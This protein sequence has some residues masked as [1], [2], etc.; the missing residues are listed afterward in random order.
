M[1]ERL[2]SDAGVV[3]EIAFRAR[4]GKA[5][6]AWVVWSGE[7]RREGMPGS[8]HHCTIHRAAISVN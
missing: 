1:S 6:W 4:P 2:F 8:G 7:L 5:G 3:L